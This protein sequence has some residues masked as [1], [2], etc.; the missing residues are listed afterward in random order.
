M[1]VVVVVVMRA[2][3]VGRRVA[4]PPVAGVADSPRA[5]SKA[6]NK[7][8]THTLCLYSSTTA[9]LTLTSGRTAVGYTALATGLHSHVTV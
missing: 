5:P 6:K 3:S 9:H 7:Q 8:Q 1:V 4:G 2:R